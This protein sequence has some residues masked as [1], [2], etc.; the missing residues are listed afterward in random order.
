MENEDNQFY[1]ESGPCIR[2]ERH[3]NTSANIS[4]SRNHKNPKR[5][6]CLVYNKHPNLINKKLILVMMSLKMFSLGAKQQTLRPTKERKQI[7]QFDF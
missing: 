7:L 2:L 6:L 3:V 1:Y 4:V 5:G